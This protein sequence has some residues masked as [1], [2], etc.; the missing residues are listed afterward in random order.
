LSF[1]SNIGGV[2]IFLLSAKISWPQALVL[3]VGAA[4]GGFIGGNLVKVLPASLVRSII[5]TCGCVMTAV[6]VYRFWL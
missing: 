4:I 2:A 1:T 3:M 6:Y 5:G